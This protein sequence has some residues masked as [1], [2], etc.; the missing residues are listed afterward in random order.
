MPALI[1]TLG[2]LFLPDT[3]NSLLDRGHPE[4]AE[5]VLRSVRGV[6]D[7]S[8]E[9]TDIQHAAKVARNTGSRWTTIF[10]RKYRA[11]LTMVRAGPPAGLCDA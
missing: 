1:L 6:D 7:V 10:Q 11:E 9:L 2:A 5:R 3:P 8:V 4:E